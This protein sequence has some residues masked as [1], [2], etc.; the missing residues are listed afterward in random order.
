MR[1]RATRMPLHTTFFHEWVW[2]VDAGLYDTFRE[3]INEI[4]RSFGLGF[5][6]FPDSDENMILG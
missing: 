2:V 1:E 4:R 6:I 3:R 5:F